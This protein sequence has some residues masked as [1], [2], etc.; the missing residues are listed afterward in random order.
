MIRP[1][2]NR[3]YNAVMLDCANDLSPA[4]FVD[5]ALHE[6]F[7]ERFGALQKAARAGATPF[8]FDDALGS[9]AK[10]TTLVKKYGS[11]IVF[12]KTDYD[13]MKELQEDI[14]FPDN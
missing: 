2:A 7:E 10:L 3:V 8:E 12:G 5:F 14:S 6:N 4:C 13:M 11:D 9:G 1:V